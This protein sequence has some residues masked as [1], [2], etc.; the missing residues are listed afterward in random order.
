MQN[1]KGNLSISTENI[2]PIIKKW[3]YSEKDIFIRELV[4]NASDAIAK[5]KRVIGMGEA[6][7][8]G[9][10]WRI[11]VTVDKDNKTIAISDNGIGM[12]EEEVKKYIN[13]IA[14]SGAKEFLEKYKD[15]AEDAQIIGHFGLGFYSAFM[16]SAKVRIDTLSWQ[17]GAESV[18][19]ESDGAGEYAMGPS[20]RKERGTTVTLFVAGDEAEFVD[21][22]KVREA[23]VKY[24]RFL[25]YEIYLT[26]AADERKKAKE[27]K[28]EEKKDEAVAEPP[29]PTPI[30]DVNPLWNK[31]AKDCTDEEYKKFYR[32]VF[33]DYAEPLFWVH[34]N[35]DYPFQ[36]KGILYFPRLKNEFDTIEGQVKLYCNQVFVADNIKEVI[37]EYLLLLKGCIDAPDLPLNVSRSF[38][39]NDGSVK[40]LSGH[41]TKKV[42]DKLTSLFRDERETYCKYWDSINPF[43]KFGC[44]RD[45]KF[46]DIVKDAVI[47]KTI[48]GDYKTVKE[49]LDEFAKAEEAQEPDWE[50]E[51]TE[52]EHEGHDHEHEHHEPKMK[53][54]R[55]NIVYYVSDEKQQAQYVSMFK[56]HGLNAVLLNTLIDSHFITFLE[57]KLKDT[58]FKRIDSDL[59]DAV[60]G[61]E[62]AVDQSD[63]EALEKVIKAVD[64]KIRVKVD[65]LK[66]TGAPAIVLLS[67]ESRRMQE[68]S[69]LYAGMNM[70]DMPPFPADETLVLNADHALVKK[71]AALARDEGKKDDAELLAAQIHDLAMLSHRPLEPE[72]LAKFLERSAKV[73]EKLG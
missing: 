67:E 30:N 51:E 21:R 29:V 16:V 34:L 26:D 13:Q 24:F 61:A 38:L 1:E 22:W 4:A 19:W 27:K 39:Q 52:H 14:F 46:Y 43:I 20:E 71:L 66:E 17:P 18:M 32:E 69:K 70:G 42:G 68:M 5:M 44:M 72:A 47:F 28:K 40:K 62:T 64:E 31:P 50:A 73:L 54:V 49:Y 63:A 6:E 58:R 57:M 65:H 33:S 23:L 55:R 35:I 41:I 45:E 10:G 60:R 12:T 36:L 8:D 56:V 9:H 59:T 7:D 37:P 3:L 15:K 48:N 25:P 53:T 11:D 2:F